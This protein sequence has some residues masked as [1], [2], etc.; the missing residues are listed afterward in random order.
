MKCT[1]GLLAALVLLLALAGCQSGGDQGEKDQR[2]VAGQSDAGDPAAETGPVQAE[3]EANGFLLRLHADRG[4]YTT[5]DAIE[6]WAELTYTGEEDTVTIWHGEPYVVFSLTDGEDFNV[7]GV[8]LTTLSGTE[9][10]KGE[11]YR[12]DYVKSGGFDASA[13]DA[14]FWEEFYQ[15]EELRLPAGTYTVTADGA[16]HLSQDL[17]PEE[18]GPSCSL[19]ITVK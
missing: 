14:A 1:A 17:L 8:I 13:P 12:F 3:A 4:T 19:Q 6:I 15:E 11:T 9:L 16:F 2:T 18:K 7:D 5:E 10:E